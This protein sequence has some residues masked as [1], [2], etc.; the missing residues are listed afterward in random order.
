MIIRDFTERDIE[1]IT[2][3]M[4]KL[5]AI[6]QQKF[7]EERW[8]N[9]IEKQQDSSFRVLVALDKQTNHVLGMTNCSIRTTNMGF[10]FGYISNLIVAEEKRRTGIG[11]LLMR[12]VID[13][14]KGQHIDSIRLALKSEIEDG[15]ATLLFNKLGF[16]EITRIYELNI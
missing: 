1:E 15:G 13:Y 4:K 3:L 11:E 8:R 9:S 16:Q 2:K 6:K 14:F 10:R 7:D 5:C 12:N